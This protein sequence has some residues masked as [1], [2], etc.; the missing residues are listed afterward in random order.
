MD[1]GAAWR[2]DR[3]DRMRSASRGE[4]CRSG[5]MAPHRHTRWWLLALVGVAL[6]L[7]GCG[8]QSTAPP[9]AARPAPA[10]EVGIRWRV[11]GSAQT[12]GPSGLEQGDTD[13][14]WQRLY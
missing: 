2:H 5:P 12:P 9:T 10:N 11:G 7:P 4:I 14:Y 3:S 6:V 1:R 13:P 8:G